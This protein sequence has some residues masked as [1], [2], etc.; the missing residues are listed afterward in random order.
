VRDDGLCECEYT[1][2]ESALALLNGGSGDALTGVAASNT[3][4][5]S[6]TSSSSGA[7]GE[8]TAAGRAPIRS[9]KAPFTV[10]VDAKQRDTLIG[11]LPTETGDDPT[12]LREA[13]SALRTQLKAV[14]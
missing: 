12:L 6:C 14:R 10:H 4:S 11:K 3:A 13:Y 1:F 8:V 9:A 2:I 7:D 5:T